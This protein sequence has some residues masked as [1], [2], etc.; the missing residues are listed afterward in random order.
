MKAIK[1][2]VTPEDFEVIKTANLQPDPSR[3]QHMEPD[4]FDKHIPELIR[5]QEKETLKAKTVIPDPVRLAI[6]VSLGGPLGKPE[7]AAPT[8]PLTPTRVAAQA[9]RAQTAPVHLPVFDSPSSDEAI[10]NLFEEKSSSDE[11][12]ANLNLDAEQIAIIP[13]DLLVADEIR[14]QQQPEDRVPLVTSSSSDDQ[15]FSTIQQ[16]QPTIVPF[17][18]KTSREKREKQFALTERKLRARP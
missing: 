9:V 7:A 2:S 8:A 3:R 10:P 5:E 17:D 13:V 11:N 6:N 4:L 15:M 1:P 16:P 14:Q 12:S 18:I